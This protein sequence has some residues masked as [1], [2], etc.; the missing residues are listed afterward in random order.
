MRPRAAPTQRAPRRA[1]EPT[2]W[3]RPR[4]EAAT[5]SGRAGLRSHGARRRRILTA[6]KTLRRIG[7]RRPTGGIGRPSCHRPWSRWSLTSGRGVECDPRHNSLGA[8]RPSESRPDARRQRTMEPLARL[9][10][11]KLSP[12]D[13]PKLGGAYES[14]GAVGGVGYVRGALPVRGRRVRVQGQARAGPYERRRSSRRRVV[15]PERAGPDPPPRGPGARLWFGTDRGVHADR[16]R[17][18]DPMRAAVA[19]VCRAPTSDGSKLVF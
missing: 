4:H 17:V 15:R 9:A 1:I 12:P 18:S 11:L 6:T 10:E 16:G 13:P 7:R 2:D 5:D 3:S 8:M 14:F 19:A